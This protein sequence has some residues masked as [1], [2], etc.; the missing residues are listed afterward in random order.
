MQDWVR[1][2]QG[3]RQSASYKYWAEA[4]GDPNADAAKLDKYSA[5]RNADKVGMPLLIIHGEI[6]QTVPREQS[7]MMAKSLEKAGKTHELVILKGMDHY[8]RPDQGDD[9]KLVLTKGKEFFDRYIGPGWAP[10]Q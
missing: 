5:N 10:P 4:I 8:L 2:E 1:E 9:W 6:D 3:G 7:E